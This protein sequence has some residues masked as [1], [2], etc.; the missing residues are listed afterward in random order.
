MLRKLAITMLVVVSLVAAFAVSSPA[1]ASNAAVVVP[2]E[3]SWVGPG[4]YVGT[5]GEDEEGTIEMWVYDVSF[6]GNVQRFST[7]LL[8]SLD[9]RTLRANLEGQFNFATG[10]VV[11]NGQVVEGWLRGAQVHEE[12]QYVGD[13]EATGGPI[14]AGTIRVMPGS[15]D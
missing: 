5:A 1:S 2:F 7:T 8:L 10:R 9:G 4:H 3:K 15:A 14:F 11:L 13:D 6:T 12:S